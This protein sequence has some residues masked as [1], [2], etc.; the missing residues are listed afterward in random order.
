MLSRTQLVVLIAAIVTIAILTSVRSP[1][2][3]ILIAIL[4]AA[5]GILLYTKSPAPKVSLRLEDELYDLE[6]DHERR[7]R[8]L[9]IARVQYPG[10]P[11]SWYWKKV[12]EDL[13]TVEEIKSDRS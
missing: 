7:E 13:R 1:I 9:E 4:L 11:E 3:I 6:P 5:A 10:Q 2:V 12:I 8:L